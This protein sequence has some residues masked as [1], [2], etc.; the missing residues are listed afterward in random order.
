MDL[1]C[2][3]RIGYGLSASIDLVSVA[4]IASFGCQ[5]RASVCPHFYNSRNYGFSQSAPVV[6]HHVNPQVSQWNNNTS[7]TLQWESIHKTFHPNRHRRTIP[8]PIWASK[9]TKTANQKVSIYSSVSVEAQLV[10]CSRWVLFSFP[11]PRQCPRLS[12]SSRCSWWSRFF[13]ATT[14]LKKVSQQSTAFIGAHARCNGRYGMERM[15]PRYGGHGRCN[16]LWINCAVGGVNSNDDDGS[17]S[18]VTCAIDQMCHA[19]SVRGGPTQRTR[20]QGGVQNGLSNGQSPIATATSGL[21]QGE[22]FGVRRRIV[23]RF[24]SI[25]TR[26]QN[27][28]HLRNRLCRFVERTSPT[29]TSARRNRSRE[30]L[31][32]C[33]VVHDQRPNGYFIV[34]P[35]RYFGLFQRQLHKVRVD[36]HNWRFAWKDYVSSSS[37][38]ESNVILLPRTELSL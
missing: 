32:P 26:G 25:A 28:V 6:N 4:T 36:L 37:A 7:F 29:K 35:T 13:G 38:I 15:G 14:L 16:V 21:A 8:L 12:Y 1:T 30:G 5:Y 10:P 17:E 19:K 34:P 33:L 11:A 3:D 24:N 20:L 9:T 23:R 31:L 22:Q 27:L 18:H 2:D